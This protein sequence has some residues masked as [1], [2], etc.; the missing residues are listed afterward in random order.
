MNAVEII[1]VLQNHGFEA[2]IVGG[3]VRDMILGIPPKDEDVVTSANPDQII[4]LFGYSRL[5]EVGKSFGVMLIDDIEVASY[6]T[7]EYYGLDDKAVQINF[8]PTLEEDVLRRDLT[9]NALCYDPFKDKI[10][11]FCGGEKDLKNKIIRFIGD[12]QKRI[13]ED[14]NR[15]IRACRFKAKI[16]G[17]F[18]PMTFEALKEYSSSV[19]SCVK[20][21]RIRIEIL[22]AMEIKNASIFFEAMKDIGILEFIFPSMNS[23]FEHPHGP[24]H[25]EDIFTHIML[26]GDSAPIKH[27]L[28]KL[29]AY[30]HDVGKPATCEI[31]PRTD[32]F[33]FLDHAHVGAKKLKEELLKLKFSTKEID[34]V[35][36]L[37]DL[38]MRVM[39][40]DELSQKCVRR[41]IK[42]L[43]ERELHYKDLLRLNFCDTSGRVNVNKKNRF[44]KTKKLNKM[45]KIE[46]NR[47]NPVGCFS[48]LE[49]NGADIQLI[50]DI[51]PG[52]IIGEILN[53]LMEKVIEDPDLNDKEE[54]SQIV[55]TWFNER[56]QC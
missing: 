47:P 35:T 3:A 44:N 37:I 52:K 24:H 6:R 31:N 43:N 2:Y 19:Q 20:P 27:K 11:D 8:A 48:Q 45:F 29:S 53:H 13:W 15:I 40:P 1:K 23:C 39:P 28:V 22:K 50:L 33:F 41:I 5:K 16:N 38:H 4:Y 32:D 51:K 9:I 25:I 12:P 49:L 36:G 18:D 10:I 54:L 42:I 34:F 26:S 46:L 55:K 56:T 14:P 7:D 21:E 17:E 30:L